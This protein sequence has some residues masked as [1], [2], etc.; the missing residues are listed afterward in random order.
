MA[1]APPTIMLSSASHCRV[2]ENV[3][4]NNAQSG[5]SLGIND[6]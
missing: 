2:V 4:G 1:A 6:E 5:T 3:Q